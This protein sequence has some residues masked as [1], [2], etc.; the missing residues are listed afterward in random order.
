[1]LASSHPSQSSPHLVSSVSEEAEKKKTSSIYERGEGPSWSWQVTSKSTEVWGFL[2]I[3]CTAKLYLYI[4][5]AD[6]SYTSK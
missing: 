3:V 6:K 2:G 1:M 5:A 4:P